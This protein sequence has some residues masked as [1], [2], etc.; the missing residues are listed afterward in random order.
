[1]K[2]LL[3]GVYA[4]QQNICTLTIGFLTDFPA[5]ITQSLDLDDLKPILG[6]LLD[7]NLVR[8]LSY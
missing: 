1:M 6:R 7:K 2:E 5:E 8:N 4:L 3:E